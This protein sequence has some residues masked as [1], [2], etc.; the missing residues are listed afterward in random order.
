[1]ASVPGAERPVLVF[2]VLGT[3]VDQ[4]GSLAAH[5]SATA[6][7]DSVEAASVAHTWLGYVAA[8]EREIVA[9]RRSFA[10]SH[11]LDR[12]AVDRLVD[13]G[14]VPR[15]SAEVLSRASE[16]LTPWPDSLDGLEALSRFSTV[17]GLSNA[18]RRVLAAVSGNAGM[19]W[20]QVLSA[21]D[22]RTYKPDRALYEVALAASPA[23]ADPPIMV[24]A[25]AW[26]LRAAASTGMRTAYVPRP[27]GDAPLPNDDFDYAAT[28]L[29]DLCAQ[30]RP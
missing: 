6:G 4:S 2:D 9:G 13:D 11:V 26:D 1:M 30:L 17:V 14:S 21:E 18:S 3:L 15:E 27:N 28:S 19:R 22:A 29:E 10:A 25:H 8:E 5:L 7:L 20:H 23:S 12:E 24:A 16:H